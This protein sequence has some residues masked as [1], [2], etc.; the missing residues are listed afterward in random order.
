MANPHHALGMSAERAVAGWLTDAGWRII[1]QRARSPGGGE[2]D[3]LAIDPRS[4]LVAVEVRARRTRRT[5]EAAMT[6]DPRRVA[7]LRRTLVAHAAANG[8]P[9]R[10]LRVDLV[11][12]E[13]ATAV[14]RWRL[15]RLPGIG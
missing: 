12:V 3:L 14:G 6:V 4:T 10:S 13:P 7:R 5:G 15:V 2:V 1:A 11:A 9:H 8:V